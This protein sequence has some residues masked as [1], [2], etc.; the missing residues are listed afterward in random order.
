MSRKLSLLLSS[1]DKVWIVLK[2]RKQRKTR[3]R[4]VVHQI[5]K[6]VNLLQLVKENQHLQVKEN[7]LLQAKENLLLKEKE[8]QLLQVKV[9]KLQQARTNNLRLEKLLQERISKL[10]LENLQQENKQSLKILNQLVNKINKIQLI[11][12]PQRMALIKILQV[13]NDKDKEHL[14]QGLSKTWILNNEIQH[15]AKDLK[16]VQDKLQDLSNLLQL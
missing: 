2:E 14:N 10:Q 3:L 7:P 16:I 8:N 5:Q 11:E 9:N 13:D 15:R 1:W 4:E 12:I 6:E